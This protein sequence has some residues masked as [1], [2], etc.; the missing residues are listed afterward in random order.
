[1]IDA[2][3][4]TAW[5][6]RAAITLLAASLFASLHKKTKRHRRTLGLASFVTGAAHATFTIASPLV[7]DAAHLIYEPHLRAGATTLLVLAILAATSFPK[8]L[9][10]PEWQALHRAIYAASALAIHH[11]ALSSHATRL[12]LVLPAAAIS[13]ALVLRIVRAVSSIQTNPPAR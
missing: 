7:E 3:A 12:S 11:L 1:M 9:K 2:L 6:G 13:L 5:S 10:I 4:I 8:Y